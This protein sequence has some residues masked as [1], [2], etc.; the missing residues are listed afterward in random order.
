ML[1]D[2]MRL[3]VSIYLEHNFSV[4]G[5]FSNDVCNEQVTMVARGGIQAYVGLQG[6]PCKQHK[7][8]QAISLFSETNYNE[9]RRKFMAFVVKV[10]KIMS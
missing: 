4:N 1:P 7:L 8:S 2:V 10:I 3:E 6:R 5:K 9:W